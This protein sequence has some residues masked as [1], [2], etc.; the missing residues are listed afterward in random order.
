M[1]STSS[2]ALG[3]GILAAHVFADG[4]RIVELLGYTRRLPCGRVTVHNK[5]G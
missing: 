5:A 1:S 4:M 3:S 2:S